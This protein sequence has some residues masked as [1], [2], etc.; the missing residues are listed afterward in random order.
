MAQNENLL[1]IGAGQ[2]G[3][4]VYELA[5][6]SKR[7]V[8]ID[9]LDDHA[10]AAIGAIADAEK[11]LPSYSYAVVAV[12]NAEFRL[13]MLEKL[14]RAGFKTVTLIA[15]NAYVSPSA[16]LGPGCIIEPC[17]VVQTNATLGV[18]CI[19]S[20]GAVVNHDAC[21]GDGCHINCNAIVAARSKVPPS[22]KVNYGQVF[23][24]V[25]M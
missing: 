13:M 9:F 5:A 15:P 3:K 22:T 16:K 8:K 24:V 2:Y 6:Q 1:I 12:G 20:A 17:A 23:S 7:F 4:L 14:N 18:G 25:E 11:F 21:V 10:G 19:V